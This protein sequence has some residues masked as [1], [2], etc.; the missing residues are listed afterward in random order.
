MK[1]GLPITMA[2]DPSQIRSGVSLISH[3]GD[4][5]VLEKRRYVDRELGGR[6]RG[7]EG[8]RSPEE[9]MAA[10][11]MALPSRRPG[12]GRQ[13]GRQVYAM[14]GATGSHSLSA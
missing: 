12:S 10:E 11:S 7:R 13:G 1:R 6:E 4:T 3:V 2:K 5:Q 14:L 8:G 9:E